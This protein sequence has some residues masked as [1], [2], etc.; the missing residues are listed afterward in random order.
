MGFLNSI[1]MAL[2]RFM[3][4]R[5]GADQLGMFTLIAGL[6]ISLLSGIVGLPWLSWIGLAL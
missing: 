4:G 5:Y 3:Q 2:A 1:K 6:L